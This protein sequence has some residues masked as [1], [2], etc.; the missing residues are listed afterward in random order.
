M[1]LNSVIRYDRLLFFCLRSSDIGFLTA[2]AFNKNYI[3][4][5]KSLKQGEA[6][7]IIEKINKFSVIPYDIFSFPVSAL[8]TLISLIEQAFIKYQ[9][10]T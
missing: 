4:M 6:P 8:R 3:T 5:K 9:L 10:I 1:R 7:V 2:Q